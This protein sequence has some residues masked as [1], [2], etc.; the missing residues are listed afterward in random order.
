[1]SKD[2]KLVIDNDNLYFEKLIK[3]LDN[4]G[5]IS[6][7]QVVISKDLKEEIHF[8][9]N[10]PVKIIRETIDLDHLCI[11]S[12]F[13]FEEVAEMPKDIIPDL[14]IRKLTKAFSDNIQDFPIRT[15]LD[16]KH[17]SYRW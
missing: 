10:Q 15:S 7:R 6:E 17:R 4:G 16:E 11:S 12:M 3:R 2:Y 1:M 14:L 8:Y 9:K 5:Q 13:S